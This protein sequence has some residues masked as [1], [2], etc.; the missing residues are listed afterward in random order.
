MRPGVLHGETSEAHMQREG[1]VHNVIGRSRGRNTDRTRVGR[2]LGAPWA[3][4]HLHLLGL[5]MALPGLPVAP[6][7]SPA[8][9]TIYGFSWPSRPF[10]RSS[11]FRLTTAATRTSSGPTVY[12]TARCLFDSERWTIASLGPEGRLSVS[13]PISNPSG[14]VEVILGKSQCRPGMN[15]DS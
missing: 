14:R 10:Y 4:M 7:W 9:P 13:T 6:P 1:V 3:R 12:F 8:L 5:P 2:A 11:R 15:V